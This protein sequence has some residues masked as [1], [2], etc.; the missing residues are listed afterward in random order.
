VVFWVYGVIASHAMFGLILALYPRVDSFA[1][2]AL[3]LG[4]LLYTAWIMRAVWI[5]AFNV[6]REV[7]GHVARALTVAWSLNAV[8]VS[9]FLLLGRLGAVSVPL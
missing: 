4:F 6:E 5:N 9:T 8:L 3:L 2:A 7:L 1:L